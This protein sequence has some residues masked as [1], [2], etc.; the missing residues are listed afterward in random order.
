MLYVLQYRPF[1]A[2]LTIWSLLCLVV[3]PLSAQNIYVMPGASI[4]RPLPFARRPSLVP[5]V[6]PEGVRPLQL[7]V[8]GGPAIHVIPRFDVGGYIRRDGLVCEENCRRFTAVKEVDEERLVRAA[9]EEVFGFDVWY[10]YYKEKELEVWVRKKF[11]LKI[12]HLKG[13]VQFNSKG[14][15]YTFKSIF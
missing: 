13:E 3:V 4:A 6:Y 9:W 8:T 11:R 2:V 10:P 1:T 14:F 15:T 7:P 12:F 5:F